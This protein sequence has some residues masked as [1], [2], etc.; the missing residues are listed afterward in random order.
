MTLETLAQEIG[1]ALVKLVREKFAEQGHNLT[2][3][4]SKSLG[5]ASEIKR[6]KL[7][8]NLEG[9]DYG[10]IVNA[11]TEPSRIPYSPGSGKK[12]SKYITALTAYAIARNM[13]TD[14]KEALRI[15]FAIARKQKQEGMPTKASARFSKTGRRKDFIQ[16][17]I[18]SPEFT[19]IL[20][21]YSPMIIETQITIP[22]QP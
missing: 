4:F 17:A 8:I 10:G 16:E 13:T 12:R 15:A 22:K 9:E 3:K 20:D 19:A 2:G 5:F 1:E 6:P 11:G 21:R 7:I 18:D 14:P